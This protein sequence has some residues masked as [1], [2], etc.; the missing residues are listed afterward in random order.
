MVQ[1]SHS[2]QA[3]L[4]VGCCRLRGSCQLVMVRVWVGASASRSCRAF[5]G[6]ALGCCL[7]LG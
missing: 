1:A 3:C 5:H 4:V 7:V 6:R 2:C